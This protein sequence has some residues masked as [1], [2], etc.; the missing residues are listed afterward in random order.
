MFKH[1][2]PLVVGYLDPGTGSLLFSVIMGVV[3]TA[4]FLLKGLYYKVLGVVFGALGWKSPVHEEE[5][6]LVLYSEGRQYFSSFQPLLA[7]LERRGRPCLFLTSDPED[8]GLQLA[9]GTIRTAC[10]GAG[11]AAWRRLNTLK[12]DLCLMTTP[13]LDVLQIKRSKGVAH[14][15]HLIH[16]PT[17]KAFNRAFSF[18]YFDSVLVCGDHQVRTL[19]VL[20]QRR[21]T[22]AKDLID[23]GCVYYDFMKERLAGLPV[24]Q[25]QGGGPASVLVAPTWGRNGLLRRYG[26]RILRPLLDAGLTVTVRPHPQSPISEPEVIADLRGQ[27]AAYP[28]LRWDLSSDPIQAMAA[29]D[30]MLSDISGVI[31]DYA[32]L[33]EK[34]VLTVAFTPDKRGMEASD[35]PYEPWELTVLDSIGRQLNEEDFDRLPDI[36]ASMAAS[37]ESRAA[38]RDL[39][40][41]SVSHFGS[42]T[43][44]VVD[45]IETMLD[46]V[47]AE[48]A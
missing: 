23:C 18:D 17:D 11:H 19:R 41:R 27:L 26:A 9:S 5:H 2:L 40:A 20:E 4:Y 31:F 21:G 29:S 16:A 48:R 39:R 37:D 7:E 35:L 28:N 46:R 24:R 47:K 8:P 14:Y 12:A 6:P 10:I 25:G 42:A 13:G 36:V 3:T 30:V 43:P 45:A 38:I 44:R 1:S 15:A 22:K 33:F 32:F 34:P